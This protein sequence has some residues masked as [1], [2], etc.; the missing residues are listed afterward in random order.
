MTIYFSSLFNNFVVLFYNRNIYCTSTVLICIIYLYFVRILNKWNTETTD[1]M[2]LQSLIW[3]ACA[4]LIIC[5]TNSVLTFHVSSPPLPSHLRNA[6]H[7]FGC[8][9]SVLN[10]DGLVHNFSSRKPL[11]FFTFAH[12]FLLL[13]FAASFFLFHRSTIE[14]KVAS[15]H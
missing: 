15:N 13:S 7:L 4:K 1:L 5:A 9:S 6:R 10:T 11:S 8:I 12:S 2:G 14:R 3:P